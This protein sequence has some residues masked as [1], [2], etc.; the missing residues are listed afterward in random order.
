VSKETKGA[1]LPP[2]RRYG[3]IFEME[4][5]ESRSGQYPSTEGF[6]QL[7]TSLF[8][9]A[10]SPGDLGQGVRSRPG[11]TPYLE[12]VTNF[13]LARALDTKKDGVSLPFRAPSDKYRLVSRGL[14]V[15]EAVLVR[16][17]VPPPASTSPVPLLVDE[18]RNQQSATSQVS[19]VFGL[20]TLI[21]KIVIAPNERDAQE[22]R[23]DYRDSSV[24]RVAPGRTQDSIS[25][26]IAPEKSA[27]DLQF[28][29]G[30][31]PVPRAKSP[32]FTVLVELLSSSVGPLLNALVT[33]LTD[34]HVARGIRHV[35]GLEEY[36]T[37]ISEALF[38]QTPPTVGSAR[39]KSS[40]TS[41]ISPQALLQPLLPQ[42]EAIALNRDDA[43]CWRETSIILALRLLCAAAAREESFSKSVSAGRT[44]LKII[45]V[46]RFNRRSLLPASGIVV[47][48]VQVSRLA[49][50]LFSF[51]RSAIHSNA[52]IEPFPAVIQYVQCDASTIAH[53]G[54]IASPAV[55]LIYYASHSLGTNEGIRALVG[56]RGGGISR[57]ATVMGKRLSRSAMLSASH[58]DSD[59]AS[60]I[61]DSILSTFRRRCA[62]EASISHVILGLPFMV[63]GGN[64]APGTYENAF[65]H[66]ASMGVTRDCFD[67]ILGCLSSLEFLTDSHSSY[68]ATK[69]FEIMYRL[70][71][72]TGDDS[73][74]ERRIRYA[75]N[76][77]RSNHFWTMNLMLFLADHTSGTESL[78]RL[79][80][81]I[82][83][84]YRP[85]GIENCLHCIAWLLK[86]VSSEILALDHP[87]DGST[88]GQRCQ[89]L[90][91][92][93]SSPYRLLMNVLVSMPISDD[94]NDYLGQEGMPSREALEMSRVAM[95]GAPEV[96]EGYTCI[97]K[98]KLAQLCS[99]SSSLKEQMLWAD[100]WNAWISWDCAASH[101]SVAIL[102][103]VE[104]AMISIHP[105]AGVG[106]GGGSSL[107][108]FELH[109]PVD[110]MKEIL[111]RLVAEGSPKMDGRLSP[112]VSDTL[113]R[114]VLLLSKQLAPYKAAADVPNISTESSHIEIC[115]LLVQAVVS[116]SFVDQG[117]PLQHH[118]KLRTATFGLALSI[119]MKSNAEVNADELDGEFLEASISLGRIATSASSTS[120]FEATGVTDRARATHIAQ[121]AF[122]S[123]LDLYRTE[124]NLSIVPLLSAPAD[125]G[126]GRTVIQSIASLI[127]NQDEHVY[128][129]A[130]KVV[131]CSEGPEILLDARLPQA[132][133]QAARDYVAQE[134]KV[135]EELRYSS[136]TLDI[137]AFLRGH[138]LLIKSLLLS[139]ALPSNRRK[140]LDVDILDVLLT[141]TGVFH[142]IFNSFH[143]NT[144]VLAICLQCLSLCCNESASLQDFVSDE[145]GA[146]WNQD[147][148]Q[149]TYVLSQNPLPREYLPTL[150]MKINDLGQS[151]PVAGNVFVSDSNKKDSSWWDAIEQ[152]SQTGNGTNVLLAGP[153]SGQAQVFGWRS[154][155]SSLDAADGDRWTA[156][157]YEM[158]LMGAEMLESCLSYLESLSL[159]QPFRSLDVRALS[160]GLCRC[161]DVAKVSLVRC[162]T[163][164]RAPYT[165][166]SLRSLFLKYRELTT[167]SRRCNVMSLKLMIAPMLWR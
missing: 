31:P 160:R 2:E 157:K 1:W 128:H 40:D 8:V 158:A 34:D 19:H 163:H 92:L 152:S 127:A 87:Y 54:D 161:S 7:L 78:L 30:A 24:V 90:S 83:P 70:T 113:S 76:M 71:E 162:F 16:Y 137:P 72:A 3:I 89:L 58:V 44:L 43:V 120:R 165:M 142:R 107:G 74:S 125:P 111:S 50:L 41:H 25:S 154:H 91:L 108:A 99:S 45:P 81:S 119:A 115:R 32:G 18:K 153:P 140:Q 65:Q 118:E 35:C 131:I 82:T 139:P 64:W 106:T 33:V 136:A 123:V 129:V 121:V 60:L 155:P 166:C 98:S 164:L 122:A 147:I 26:T 104:S 63:S 10:G 149:L 94:R 109:S 37:R 13:V 102:Y 9:A 167:V 5:I 124:E 134:Q 114:I 55:A 49:D 51:G 38:G 27:T 42:L 73:A 62:R 68:L 28:P 48:N 67:A 23:L 6:L 110:M 145:R 69:C 4:Q 100:G 36:K 15:I 93:F 77:L 97:N 126:V 47:R 156:S 117:R 133:R 144:E 17:T 59:I 80:S 138:M 11:C 29:G 52:Y 86:S 39:A 46:L 21:E 105:S 132:I 141:Y 96:V 116:S 101:L 130:E 20:S 146:T 14:E 103:L 53:D 159:V 143:Q 79:A 66:A 135:M 88:S 84:E 56:S 151:V 12:Y 75:A 57:F 22:A 85:K 61:L 148:L 95:S 150:P 112:N